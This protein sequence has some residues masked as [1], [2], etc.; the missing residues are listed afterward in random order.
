MCGWSTYVHMVHGTH[1][2]GHVC[3]HQVP[4]SDFTPLP[5]PKAA[6]PLNGIQNLHLALAPGADPSKVDFSNALDPSP[7]PTEVAI[8]WVR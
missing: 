7:S 6:S 5:I 3:V 4:K 1:R 2:L 8:W